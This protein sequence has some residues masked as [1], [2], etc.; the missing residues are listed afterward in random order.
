MLMTTS[1]PGRLEARGGMTEGEAAALYRLM[2]WLS[3]AFPVGAFSYSSGIEWAVEAGDIADAA[4]LARL[5]GRDARRR[6]RDFATACSWRRR[7]ARRLRDDDAGCARSPSWRRAFVPSRERQLETTTQGRAFIE[8]ARAAWNCAGLD[9]TI[10]ACDGADRLSRRGRPRQR[11]ARTYRLRRRCTR[12]SMRWCRTGFP[13]APGSIPLG[14]TDSQRVLADLEPIVVADREARARSLARRSR[15]RDLS[16][17]SRQPAPRDAVYEA[18]PVMMS[19]RPH[20]V[21]PANAGTHN[22][23]CAV[24]MRAV[25]QRCRNNG[26][27]V[28]WVPAFA[29]TTR[30]ED[31]SDMSNLSRPASRSASAARSARARPR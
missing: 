29:G 21:V 5:A 4:S 19:A 13:P 22:H 11:R 17:R 26:I 12:F 23:Q 8:I 1:E 14:Q 15:Q 30:I 25:G 10:A 28:V 9:E 18:V 6:M 31:A 2:T 7:T 16:R 24:V 27:H 20:H 3:P